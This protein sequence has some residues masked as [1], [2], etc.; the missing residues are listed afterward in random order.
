MDDNLVY[1]EIGD[2][3]SQPL[4][5]AV[6]NSLRANPIN[7][8]HVRLTWSAATDAATYHIYRAVAPQGPFQQVGDVAGTTFDD[9]DQMGDS[10]D[11]Y[12]RIVAADACGN[13]GP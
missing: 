13:E 10:A 3:T 6:G 2:A 9:R 8:A 1:A 5:G 11:A 4:P 7:A 12:Y